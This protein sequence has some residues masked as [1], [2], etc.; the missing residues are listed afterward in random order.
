MDMLVLLLASYHW[1]LV[2]LKVPLF[3]L[4]TS[5][6]FSADRHFEISGEAHSKALAFQGP[7][8]SF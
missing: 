7:I 6:Q 1:R 3:A 4:K 5:K 2:F 8:D